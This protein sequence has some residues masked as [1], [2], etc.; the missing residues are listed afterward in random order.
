MATR[1][2]KG[3]R[4]FLATI[5]GNPGVMHYLD[6][7]TGVAVCGKKP[8]TCNSWKMKSRVGWY[9]YGDLHAGARMC[10]KCEASKPRFAKRITRSRT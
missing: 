7:S 10:P 1:D 8:G 6:W 4:Y 5:K 2:S 9:C 3:R